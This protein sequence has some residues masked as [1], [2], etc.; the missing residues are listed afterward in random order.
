[1]SHFPRDGS[2]DHTE[3]ERISLVMDAAEPPAQVV[4][5]GRSQVT[6]VVLSKIAERV[7]LRTAAYST[8][9]ASQAIMDGGA[10]IAIL[11]GGADHREC[12]EVLDALRAR[13][14]L[15]GNGYPFVILLTTGTQDPR[16]PHHVGVIDA[17]VAK[18]ITPESLQPLL[19]AIRDGRTGT[20]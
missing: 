13:K 10:V 8:Q 12:D 20:A 5:V 18:P 2:E 7:G 17:V 15:D 19:L 1:M 9:T 4:L 3:S 6:M 16:L 14:R 11:D